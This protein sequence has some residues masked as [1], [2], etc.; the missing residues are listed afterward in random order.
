M[1]VTILF[2]EIFNSLTFLLGAL[3]DLFVKFWKLCLPSNNLDALIG[4]WGGWYFGGSIAEVHVSD[5]ARSADWI[6]ME[7]NNESNP[8]AFYNLGEEESY[9]NYLLPPTIASIVAN[10]PTGTYGIGTAIPIT[11]NFSKAVTGSNVT[12]TLNTF[13]SRFCTFSISSTTSVYRAYWEDLCQRRHRTCRP[14][15]KGWRSW[16][17]RTGE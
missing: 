16:R 8:S 14:Y 11:V 12:I 3:S 7:Y 1:T 9:E 6:K 5:I 4:D 15:S 2:W 13:T 17:G 10:L